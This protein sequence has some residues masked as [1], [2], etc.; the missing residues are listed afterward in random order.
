MSDPVALVTGASSG[1]GRSSALAMQAAGYLVYAAVRTDKA[2][3]EAASCG[4][5]PV[6]LDVTDEAGMKG[7]VTSV[8][9]V[10]GRI[11][12]LVNS[13]G[14]GI[15]GPMEELELPVL[16]AEFEV[17][18]LGLLRLSQLVLPQMR[19]RRS[20]RIIHIGSVG[21]LFTAPGAGGYHMSKYA[22]ESLSDAMR[23]EVAPFGV[24]IIL[25][26]PT[27]VRTPFIEKQVATMP[28]DITDNPYRDFK[29]SMAKAALALFEPRSMAVVTPETV[30]RVVVRAATVARP[31]TRYRV[32]LAAN[33][34]PLVR[35]WMPDRSWD[36]LM[37]KAA[38]QR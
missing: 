22:V 3:D 17:N 32:G 6:R 38:G 36:A 28:A 26:E 14:F 15:M 27:G 25:V 29:A 8:L 24:H 23:A 11:D 37:L 31:R 7:A 34:M 33:I 2:A 4:L 13:A 35:R 12:V 5:R 1:I 19:R 16:R 20:G 10:T 18:V 21:G 30:A 9:N